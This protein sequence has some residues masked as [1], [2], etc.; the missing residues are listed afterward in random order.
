[1]MDAMK[2]ELVGLLF[3]VEVNVEENVEENGADGGP[4]LEIS[5]LPGLPDEA[6][7]PDV[8]NEA[9]K[10]DKFIYT[11]PNAAGEAVQ[12]GGISKNAPCPCG[13]GRKYKRCHG[14][15]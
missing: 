4:L 3:H 2:E 11:A 8:P 6:N 1:M 9:P 7:D 13:S 5:G 10:V 14:A 15:S 12:S